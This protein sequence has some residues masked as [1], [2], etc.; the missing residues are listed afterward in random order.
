[1]PHPSAT[2]STRPSSN[3]NL[4]S[5]SGGN[6]RPPSTNVKP[7]ITPRAAWQPPPS[8]IPVNNPAPAIT[9]T[10]QFP[11]SAR[12]P[13]TK[14]SFPTRLTPKTAPITPP[15]PPTTNPIPRIAPP[16]GG[17]AAVVT[18]TSGGVVS[19]AGLVTGGLVTAAAGLLL[20][21]AWQAYKLF[22]LSQP[23]PKFGERETQSFNPNT[24]ENENYSI[25]YRA[26]THNSNDG[27]LLESVIVTDTA[28]GK[29]GNYRVTR[30]KDFYEKVFYEAQLYC[31]QTGTGKIRQEP[32]EYM[33]HALPSAVQDILKISE[34]KINGVT[35][36][37]PS[38][39]RR[40]LIKSGI[41]PSPI[42]Q[43][44]LS[45]SPNGVRSPTSTPAP[46]PVGMPLA[47]N[48]RIP[49]TITTPGSNPITITS[50][51]AAPVT[52]SPAGTP[53]TIKITRPSASPF[54]SPNPASTPAAT[55]VTTPTGDPTIT[56]AGVPI[57]V[58]SPGSAPTNL[59]M[60]GANPITITYPGQAPI[61]F[62]PAGSKPPQGVQALPIPKPGA[63]STAP[64]APIQTPTN[65]AVTPTIPTTT[66]TT[67]DKPF[68]IDLSDL[69]GDSA[70]L[71]L[72]LVGLTQLAQGTA[73]NTTPPAI[74]N[75]VCRTAAPG[76]CNNKM[77]NDAVRK[78]NED[79]KDFLKNNG[80]DAADILQNKDTNNRV[81]NIE[82]RTGS[83]RYPMTLPEYLLDDFIDKPVII[84]D[85]VDFNVWLV[86]N[87]DALVGLFP[88]KI[89]RIDE[90]GVKQ[91]L[92]FENIAE[93]IAELTGLLAQIAFDA[94]TAVNVGTR[95]TG[96]AV[97]AKAAALQ[98]GSYLKAI[99]DYMGF[100]GQPI[101]IDVPISVTPGA[102]GLDGKLQESELKDFLKP[103]VQKAIGF[104]NTDPVDQRLV[105]RRILESGEISRAA[106]FKPLK[107]DPTQNS[108][109][110]DAIKADKSAEQ[111]RINDLWE[112][113]KL[114]ME[115]HTGGT[116]VDIDDGLKPENT[117]P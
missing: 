73:A 4:P 97:G 53:A 21:D 61:V 43:S 115:S 82:N 37:T 11:T 7:A 13:S 108:L 75:A 12:I 26:T 15:P 95:A 76:G 56:P 58:S 98:A 103:S 109:T 62:D 114:R 51:G 111:K 104:K 66:P 41:T 9:I 64:L 106:L 19:G 44:I 50:P 40:S 63:F 25:T 10:P 31:K 17:G 14:L 47:T 84:Q 34:F 45:P 32:L 59:V 28:I 22:K 35:P 5:R 91:L 16:S 42:P 54:L 113:F 102:V 30:N 6:L 72:I 68:G 74:A 105:M 29:I 48:N 112:V 20:Y 90:N 23:E 52:I 55:P 87:V 33:W 18:L 79:L 117:A 39:P 38:T 80:L 86:K 81:K 60:P 99:V 67:A 78:G 24:K 3:G 77:T 65:P 107:A 88:I 71:G 46:A 89:E 85:Q 57:A 93:A 110:G 36:T 1:M 70:K 2:G 116:K 83:H 8:S 100:Q 69:S 96:E 94:D 101:S 49:Y 92:K 27:T